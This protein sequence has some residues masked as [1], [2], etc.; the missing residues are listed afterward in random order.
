MLNFDIQIWV[1]DVLVRV[2]LPILPSIMVP[3]G[4]MLTL[5]ESFGRFLLSCF[6]CVLFSMISIYYLGITKSE[7]ESITSKIRT[8]VKSYG[9]KK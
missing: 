3:M 6:I 4:I 5:P 7:R 9:Y 8:K 1:K 2:L